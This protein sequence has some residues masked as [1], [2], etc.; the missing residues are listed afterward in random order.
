M[1]HLE[2]LTKPNV[3][4]KNEAKWTANFIQSGK[5]RP[6]NSQ[7]THKEIKEALASISANKCFYSE[8]LFS[9]LSDAQVDHCIEVSE[10]K[11]KAFC[12]NNLYLA[13]KDCN[14]G[15]SPNKDIPISECLNPFTDNND[16]IEKHLYFEDEMV[17]GHTDKG[18]NTI[19]KYNLNKD[20]FNLLR[21]KHL[22]KF[23]DIIIL[24]LKGK[25]TKDEVIQFANSDRPFSL[26]IR[27]YLKKHNIIGVNGN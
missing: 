8:V 2:R 16:E 3:L 1:V 13:H 25:L 22:S 9:S 14:I 27:L 19:R 26:M 6:Q 7:Y 18:R 21:S 5:D 4:A 23:K 17:L 24:C 20:N 15:K 11:E 10:D 12:W